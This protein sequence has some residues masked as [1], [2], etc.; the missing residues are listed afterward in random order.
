MTTE[1]PTNPGTT[2]APSDE[3]IVQDLLPSMLTP[4]L[5]AQIDPDSLLNEQRRLAWERDQA[6]IADFFNNPFKYISAYWRQYKPIVIALPLIALATIAVNFV[7]MLLGFILAIPL[8]GS[9]LQL[10]G[11]VYSVWFVK[12][13][14]LT[15]KT[16]QELFEKVAQIKQAVIGTTEEIVGDASTT[17]S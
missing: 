6:T 4:P 1:L 17:T 14:L 10:I 12:R 8:M 11:F 5:E 2:V 13:Y 9:L 16:R 15:P 7:L 3:Q